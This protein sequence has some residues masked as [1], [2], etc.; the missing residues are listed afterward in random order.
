MQFRP[1][2]CVS[3]TA[4]T[5]SCSGELIPSPWMPTGES[6]PS[7]GMGAQCVVRCRL[8]PVVEGEP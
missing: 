4:L 3:S 5:N 2:Q 7:G 1:W 6:T 8:E